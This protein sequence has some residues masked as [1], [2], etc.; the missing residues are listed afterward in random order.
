[1]Q[2]VT[3]I[4]TIKHMKLDF[5]CCEADKLMQKSEGREEWLDAAVRR[6]FAS[7]YLSGSQV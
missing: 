5:K 6:P 1:M 2:C 7:L 4:I 3:R